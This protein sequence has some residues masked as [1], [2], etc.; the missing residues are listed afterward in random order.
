M[1]RSPGLF[2]PVSPTSKGG[3]FPRLFSGGGV[4]SAGSRVLD[5]L[6]NS[7]RD[8]A[9][10]GGLDYVEGMFHLCEFELVDHFFADASVDKLIPQA[11]FCL[12]DGCS[13]PLLAP[14]LAVYLSRYEVDHPVLRKHEENVGIILR[15]KR[16]LFSEILDCHRLGLTVPPAV[17]SEVGFDGA[18]F[19]SDGAVS[20]PRGA[21]EP[22]QVPDLMPAA[23]VVPSR[24][25]TLVFV[26]DVIPVAEGVYPFGAFLAEVQKSLEQTAPAV[27]SGSP[28]G[29]SA[30]M[31]R[32]DKYQP[33]GVPP[34]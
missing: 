20:L 31:E 33:S 29:I 18:R 3:L 26:R 6:R 32:R 7:D 12:T 21:S 8:F 16:A 14:H 25:S 30:G 10:H 17:S 24:L 23:G 22:W 11:A 4:S 1:F 15:E 5:R 34:L 19:L 9:E 2:E 13:R 28:G 27:F